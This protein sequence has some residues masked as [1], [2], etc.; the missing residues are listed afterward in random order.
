MVRTMVL[1]GMEGNPRLE[2]PSVRGEGSPG[3]GEG[4]DGRVGGEADPRRPK[5]QAP[6]KQEEGGGQHQTRQQE[7]PGSQRHAAEG[8]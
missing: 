4:P 8:G 2:A 7:A 6:C 5:H 1:A 3:S